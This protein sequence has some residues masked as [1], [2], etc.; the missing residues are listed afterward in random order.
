MGHSPRGCR[1]Q[2]RLS[3]SHTHF[4]PLGLVLI[5]KEEQ[6]RRT[7]G[8]HHGRTREETAVCTP[9]GEASASRSQ[10]SPRLDLQFPPPGLGESNFLLLKPPSVRCVV[11]AAAASEFPP[12]M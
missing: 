1:S 9:A 7:H 3:D 4:D 12:E 8:D 2:T 6:H 11:M 5:R 10:R